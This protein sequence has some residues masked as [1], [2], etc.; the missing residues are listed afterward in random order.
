M[1]RPQHARLPRDGWQAWCAVVG[2][3]LRRA[4]VE[5][6]EA[7]AAEPA[8]E[9]A[10]QLALAIATPVPDSDDEGLRAT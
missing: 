1:A 5:L 6:L 9:A 10:A 3:V 2:A 7:T 8:H 4:C